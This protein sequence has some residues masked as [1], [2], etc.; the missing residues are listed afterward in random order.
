M[1]HWGGGLSRQKQTNVLFREAF[2]FLT[3][4]FKCA[5]V[6]KDKAQQ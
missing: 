6:V 5:E 3:E 4:L 1:A 2:D